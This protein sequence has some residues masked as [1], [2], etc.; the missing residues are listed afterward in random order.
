MIDQ[1]EFETSG[2]LRRA[3]MEAVAEHKG[4]DV[5]TLDPPTSIDL[6]ALDEFFVSTASSVEAVDPSATFRYEG[7]LVSVDQRDGVTIRSDD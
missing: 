7:F 4:V 6:E 3:V 5:S 2:E 1:P